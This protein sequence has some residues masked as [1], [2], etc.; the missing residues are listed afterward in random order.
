M[1]IKI[2]NHSEGI[3][4]YIGS[5]IEA[6]DPVERK[7]FNEV[8]KKLSEGRRKGLNARRAY[9]TLTKLKLVKFI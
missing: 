6:G 2:G 4:N 1:E 8:Y 3:K 7:E 5:L 9:K